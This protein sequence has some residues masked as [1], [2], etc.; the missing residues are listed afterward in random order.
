MKKIRQSSDANESSFTLVK[1]YGAVS[2][3]IEVNVVKWF[4]NDPQLDIRTWYT[5][6]E[7]PTKK[8]GKGIGIPLDKVENLITILQKVQSDINN[9]SQ[10]KEE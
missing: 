3:Q 1:A 4:D 7:D 2:N 9:S 6:K 10:S 8:P 5:T